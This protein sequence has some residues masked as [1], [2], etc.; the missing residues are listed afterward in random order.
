MS[1]LS[2]DNSY[3]RYSKAMSAIAGERI[4]A[5]ADSV[6]H[7]TKPNPALTSAMSLLVHGFREIET[8]LNALS[9][10]EA[11][12]KAPAPRSRS[13]SKFDYLTFLIGAHLQEI[14]ILEQRLTTYAK[15]VGR[16]YRGKFDEEAFAQSIRDTFGALSKARGKHVHEKRFEDQ[17]IDYL[18]GVAY[19]EHLVD[20]V[21]V[22]A[23]QDYRTI[24]AEWL[25]SIKRS[26]AT[27][28]SFLQGYFDQLLAAISTDGV[29]TLPR[30]GK[31][32]PP[33]TVKLPT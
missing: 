25:A 14:Y 7:G 9:L 32:Q 8:T 31:G 13:V 24:K 4:D 33:Y 21:R 26:N 2:L 28:R 27:A 12:V 15:K 11:M 19:V 6:I 23:A 30:T 20:L 29:L 3:T 16:A 10:V 18:Q 22:K 1:A 5:A 17:R